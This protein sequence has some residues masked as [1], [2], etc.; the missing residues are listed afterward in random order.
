MP[1]GMLCSMYAVRYVYTSAHVVPDSLELRS[2]LS[3]C[4][5]K[6]MNGV[7]LEVVR[8]L[9]VQTVAAVLPGTCFDEVHR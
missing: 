8:V 7:E 9:D 1:L 6:W 2:R 3:P 4:C 5:I